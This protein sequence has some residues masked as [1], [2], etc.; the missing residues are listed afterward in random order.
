MSDSG[1]EYGGILLRGAGNWI[2]IEY[3]VEA[4]PIMSTGGKQAAPSPSPMP[5]CKH[6]LAFMLAVDG[7]AAAQQQVLQADGTADAF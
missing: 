3:A 4:S 2:G 7:A 1:G 5:S 6:P